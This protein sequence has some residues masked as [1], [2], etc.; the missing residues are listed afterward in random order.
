MRRNLNSTAYRRCEGEVAARPDG[1]KTCA[2]DAH[3]L[4]GSEKANNI[5]KKRKA[6]CETLQEV[7]LVEKV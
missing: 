7:V 4:Q 6:C 2:F 5:A 1:E 3:S